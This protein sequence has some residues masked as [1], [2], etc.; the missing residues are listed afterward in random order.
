MTDSGS[1][2]ER[3]SEPFSGPLDAAWRSWACA[4]LAGLAGYCA[5]ANFGNRLAGA[6]LGH[7]LSTDLAGPASQ[8]GP[9]DQGEAP[10][11][12][13]WAE[14]QFTLARASG[15]ISPVPLPE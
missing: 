5:L 12:E 6:G 11:A 2:D 13:Q 1:P 9:S 10:A 15:A 3:V 4:S 8:A 7:W 14:A